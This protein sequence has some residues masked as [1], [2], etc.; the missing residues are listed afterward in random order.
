MKTHS[1]TCTNGKLV[2]NSLGRCRLHAV[3]G[4]RVRDEVLYQKAPMGT[5]PDKE[6]NRAK[7]K[8]SPGRHAAELHLVGCERY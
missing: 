2:R 1:I 3:G 4:F 8:S 6:C 5:M 7:Q